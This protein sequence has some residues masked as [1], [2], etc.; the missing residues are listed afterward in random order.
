M[1]NHPKG[2]CCWPEEEAQVAPFYC[3]PWTQNGGVQF[4][5]LETDCIQSSRQVGMSEW[6]ISQWLRPYSYSMNW[7]VLHRGGPKPLLAPLWSAQ[8]PARAKQSYLRSGCRSSCS[9]QTWTV[10]LLPRKELRCCPDRCW[11][12]QPKNMQGRALSGH[13]HLVIGSIQAVV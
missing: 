5:P 1:C 6:R 9:S 12:C 10:V 8:F 2:F 3:M 7:V 11:L 13:P 4:N